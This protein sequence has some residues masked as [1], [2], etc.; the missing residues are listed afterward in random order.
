MSGLELHLLG[1]PRVERDGVPIKVDTRKATALLAYLV[2]TGESQRR[3]TLAVLLWPDA[4]QVRARA[5]LRRTVSALNKALAG[6]GLRIDRESVGLDPD[7]DVWVDIVQ[8]RTRLSESFAHRHPDS[9]WCAPCVTRLS[10]AVELSRGDYLSGFTLR[11][12]PAFDD[13]QSLQVEVFRRELATALERLVRSHAAG[14]EYEPAIEY[15]RRWLALDPLDESVHRRLMQ[16]HAWAG[17]RAAALRQYR[18]CV[19]VLDQE[20]GVP[21]LEETTE[22]NQAIRQSRSAPPARP[23]TRAGAEEERTLPA[24]T[25]PVSPSSA[26]ISSYPLVGRAAEWQTLL[27]CYDRIDADGHLIVLEGEAGIGKTRL[28]EEFLAHVRANGAITLAARC[29]VG[30]AN[31]AYGPFVEAL[32][33]AIRRRGDLEETLGGVPANQISEAARLVPELAAGRSDLPPAPPLDSPGAQSRFFA[34]IGDVLNHV[35]Q[36]PGPGVVFLDDVHWADEASLDLL[37]YLVRRL[38]GRP[39]C[40][41]VTWRTELVEPG[42][43]LRLMLAEGERA[44]YATSLGLSRLGPDDVTELV[45]AAA[46][47]GLVLPD[48]AHRRLHRETEGLPF[49]LV[50][51]LATLP[52]DAEQGSEEW[53]MPKSVREL[54]RARLAPVSGIGNQILDTAAAIGRSFDFDTLRDAGGRGDEEAVG[55]LEELMALALVNEVAGHPRTGDLR[56]DFNHEQLRVLV[57]E[58]TSLGRRRILHRRVAEALAAR[59]RREGDAG[60]RASV[61]AQHYLLAGRD[62]ESGEYFKLAGDYSRTLFA[63]AEALG[64]YRAALERGHPEEVSLHQSIGDLQTLSGD[65]RAA[66][67]SYETAAAV[68]QPPSLAEVE[69]RLGGVYLRR[70][71]WQMAE[72][73]FHAALGTLGETGHAGPRSRI[74]ADW[75]LT[76][77]RGGHTERA[78]DL[79]QRAVS[80][81]DAADDTRGLAQAHNILGILARSADQMEEACR[82]LE[83]SLSLAGQIDDPSARVAALNNLALARGAAGD[84]DKALALVEEALVLCSSQGDRHREAA[85]HNNLADLLYASDQTDAAMDHLTQAVTIFSEI[86][87]EAGTIEPE[88]WKLVEW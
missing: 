33:G 68:C 58:D 67:I 37:A 4:D 87:V 44:G 6:E 32:G 57:Y 39:L 79:A 61:I 86:G 47:T 29:Y 66:L 7:A 46:S 88:I 62:A 18:E 70:G 10:E 48:D 53:I 16:L 80:L 2:V 72:S 1:P 75:S 22:L 64:H 52:K 3:D 43:P 13:W 12:S 83:H 76:A 9:E 78:L 11:D 73:H 59:A 28:A 50:E 38:R 51:Y 27:R 63:N 41:I 36:G 35:C 49:F 81:A 55:A 25:R 26:G 20:L 77:H 54:L 14:G 82:H 21:P 5:A 60:P 85:L 56:Y 74:Y 17:Q 42:H 30:E 31:L 19:R 40:I 45:Q 69:R 23:Q 84:L 24:E 65:Y 71:D 8:F 15:A 34:A